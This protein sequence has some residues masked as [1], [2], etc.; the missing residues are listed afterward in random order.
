MHR[1]VKKTRPSSDLV[2]A[3][4]ATSDENS[5]ELTDHLRNLKPNDLIQWQMT[6][7][8][9]IEAGVVVSSYDETQGTIMVKVVPS[10]YVFDVTCIAKDFFA[11][12]Q[13]ENPTG[14]RTLLDP[15][16]R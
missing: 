5:K 15:L 9:D 11:N 3:N 2:M 16:R 8:D 7:L 13:Q 10:L 6:Y 12:E 4:N 14:S 1:T